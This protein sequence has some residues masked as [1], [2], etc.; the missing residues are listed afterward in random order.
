[1]IGII[2]NF[3]GICIMSIGIMLFHA[4]PFYAQS[5]EN[6][7]GKQQQIQGIDK[8][9]QTTAGKVISEKLERARQKYLKALTAIEND[10]T[11]SIPRLFEDAVQALNSLASYPGIESN[12]DFADL[13]QSIIDDY[14]SYVQ[15]IDSLPESSSAFMLRNKIY[16]EVE[17]IDP[18]SPAMS[19]LQFASSRVSG[20]PGVPGMTIPLDINECSKEHYVF[21]PR[22]GK[23]IL[24]TMD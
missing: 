3:Y 1:M 8:E 18:G 20:A 10:D 9:A 11:L 4:P 15:I 7:A 17:E 24:Q 23:E 14:E 12:E 5:P 6:Q 19:T 16:Q 21:V 22:Q 2:K 13:A